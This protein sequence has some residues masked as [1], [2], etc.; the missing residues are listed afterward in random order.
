MKSFLI[1]IF[2][3]FS[4]CGFSQG[5]EPSSF[6]GTPYNGGFLRG[7]TMDI[8]EFGDTTYLYEHVD[9]TFLNGLGGGGGRPDSTSVVN[10]YGTT[11][12]ESPA[13]QFN[14][15]VDSTKFFTKHQGDLKFTLP[16]LTNGS[17]I[18]S[19]GTTLA[20]D[21]SNLFWDNTNNRLG[22]GTTSPQSLLQLQ[23]SGDQFLTS[24]TT[25]ASKAGFFFNYNNIAHTG[26][27]AYYSAS[28][29]NVYFDNLYPY[30]GINNF[31]DVIWRTTPVTIGSQ[32]TAMTLKGSG[33][34]G[35]GT[36]T[37]S[38]LLDVN[39]N[40][41]LRSGLYDGA[42]LIGSSGQVLS[43]TGSATSWITP[44][45]GTVTSVAATAGPGISVSG[46]PIT[47]SGTLNITNTAPD[48]TVSIAGAG[49]SAVTG[50]YPNFTVTSTE[51]DGSTTNE[52]IVALT[53][54]DAQDSL[55]INE[56]GTIYRTKITGFGTGTLSSLNGEVGATQTFATGTSGTDFAISSATNTHTFNLPS[57]STTARGVITTSAQTIA[58]GKTFSLTGYP[59]NTITLLNPTAG[60]YGSGITFTDSYSS[61]YL[62][63]NGAQGTYTFDG[64]GAAVAN[65]K[66][67]V[68]GG[69]TIGTGYDAT[70]VSANSLNVEGTMTVGSLNLG[71]PSYGLAHD[72]TG[73]LVSTL[74]APGTVSSVGL[75]VGTSGTD[76]AIGLGSS[77]VTSTGT[78]N[79]NIPTASASNRGALSSSDWTTFNSKIGGSGSNTQVPYFNSTNTLTSSANMTYSSPRLN[80]IG[81]ADFRKSATDFTICI[82]GGSGNV[83]NTGIGSGADNVWVGRDAGRV[84]TGSNNVGSGTNA[85]YSNT[86]GSS[87]VALGLNSLFTNTT[88]SN[89][90][91]IGSYSL[92]SS[93]SDANVGIGTSAM[94]N[95][96]S[97]ASGVAIGYQAM[98]GNTTGSNNIAIGYRSLYS[99]S[100]GSGN[101]AIG[102]SAGLSETG[103]NKLYIDNSSTVSP[104][105]GGDMTNNYVGINTA[106]SSLAA[107]LH[108]TGDAIIT[109]STGTPT[110]ITGRNASG[111]I[112]NVTLSGISLSSGI[113][114]GIGGSGTANYLPYMSN[115]N[116]IASTNI[117]YNAS[118]IGFN[119]ASPTHAVHIGTG[120]SIRFEGNSTIIDVNNS[121]GPAGELLTKA[122]SGTGLDWRST[123]DLGLLTGEVDGSITNEG[124][125]GV[126][127]SG[128]NGT[129]DALLRGY[130]SAGTTT[131]N[132][133][134]FAGGINTAITESTSTNG[135]IITVS[136]NQQ[137]AE[138]EI[139][140]YVQSGGLTTSY[141]KINFISN[142]DNNGSDITAVHNGTN[143]DKIIINNFGVYKV[144]FTVNSTCNTASRLVTFAVRLNGSAPGGFGEIKQ[145]F[146]NTSQYGTW[147]FSN[148]WSLGSGD[149]L[150]LVVKANANCD[151]TDGLINFTVE[152][153]N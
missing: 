91:A 142:G 96:T 108:V 49:I 98:N 81:G 10:S 93:N 150:E 76:I 18:F 58:G 64:S 35:I 66:L 77:P 45:S 110:T 89:N 1:P 33:R 15:K 113:L 22:V 111:N 120:Q 143:N 129:N 19:N 153:L 13:N 54:N 148:N 151:I 95:T 30:D 43:S 132:G 51:V 94:F 29:A 25:S 67:H 122:A 125:L 74:V 52:K 59:T 99:N 41:R 149:Y 88:G 75:A 37:P 63:R 79:L 112:G 136:S 102:Y 137:Y 8:G 100:G 6:Q 134:T 34:L 133:T 118:G 130:N 57:A 71:T 53:W 78:I 140:G 72:A 107:T 115:S 82:G 73:K 121:G 87:N 101:I 128:A 90:M 4:L 144:S 55:Q 12:T 80:I 97:G 105:I 65:K 32:V 50:T 56:N 70:A 135:G 69:V 17:V 24:T 145:Y 104:L 47:T 2:L 39:G 62:F 31:G 3:F 83:S 38:Q 48:Q 60:Q 84:N 124:Y 40:A 127:A 11:I 109:G 92:L 116:T 141:Q 126:A 131:G 139:N 5:I 103:S 26:M 14:V 21:N 117:S 68:D 16:S 106:V 147:H 7:L 36:S 119:T 42:N 146:D 9:S 61:G 152:R 20:Q 85:M 114:S 23:G 46:S 27:K 138:F 44:T 86:S 123:S 28:D